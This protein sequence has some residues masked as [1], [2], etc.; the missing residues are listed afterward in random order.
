M[1]IGAI[2]GRVVGIVVEIIVEEYATCYCDTPLLCNLCYYS[3]TCVDPAPLR[4]PA[5]LSEYIMQVC[6]IRELCVTP[7]LYAIVGAAAVVSGVTRM[8][9]SI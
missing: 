2:M 5:Q 3:A 1:A 6:P 8:T 7:G 4:S 9:G